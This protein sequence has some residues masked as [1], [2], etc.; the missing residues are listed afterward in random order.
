[1]DMLIQLV[2]KAKD[3]DA[4]A[5]T[6]LMQMHMQSMYKVAKSI[7]WS[8]EDAADAIQD[9][10]FSCWRNLSSLKEAGYFKTW[11]IRILINKCKDYIRK[12]Q[13]VFGDEELF[14]LSSNDA[15]IENAEWKETLRQLDE[16]YRLVLM[17]YY[18]EGFKTREISQMLDVP[19]ATVRTRLARGRERLSG[20]Y[21]KN[22]ERSVL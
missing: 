15:G 5:F 21:Q 4:D 17:L 7:L 8:D 13:P 6:Q 3:G 10:I 9:T 20:I 11:M 1:M 22:G 16:K 12:S 19:E 18:I 14:G 2:Q